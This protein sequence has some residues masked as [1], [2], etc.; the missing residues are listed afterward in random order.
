LWF[1]D[2]FQGGGAVYNV[3]A[4]LRLRGALDGGALRSALDEL[5]SRHES[6]RT[7]FVERAG[8]M[9]QAIDP[10]GPMALER[11]DLSGR[12]GALAGLLEA[13][14]LRPFDLAAGPLVRAA[15]YRLSG[16]E[17]VLLLSMH[18]IVTDGWSLKL[19]YRELAA[20]YGAF[21]AGLPSPLPAPALHYADY[22]A[23]QGQWLRGA[24]PGR[25]LDYWKRRLAGAPEVLELPA[26]RPRPAVQ[27]FR[28]AEHGFSVSGEQLAGL[29]AI[30]RGAGA[31]LFAVLMAAFQATLSRLSGQEDVLVGL[32]V[33]G[34]R[35]ETEGLI[36]FFVNTLVLRTDLSGEPDFVALVGRVWASLLDAYDHQEVPFEK[37]V[38]KVAP[39]RDPSR[40]PVFQVMMAYQVEEEAPVWPAAVTA[41]PEPV[42]LPVAKFDLSLD[43]VE[44]ADGLDLRLDYATDLFDAST[45]AR[46]AG[47]FAALLEGAV[48]APER[49]VSRLALLGEA[50]LERLLVEWNDTA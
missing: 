50:E 6:L 5:V 49:P 22:A 34:R 30:A 28:G 2:R 41:S 10:A 13:Q 37:V 35:P 17:H 12:P 27:S 25:Q 45:I 47:C 38:E 14:A 33:A 42:A 32:P 26:D 39:V 3:P 29:R 19:L 16:D 40:H 7:R 20:L 23:W 48:S 46:F 31:S 9:V 24:E 15:L 43:V 4:G 1:L 8:V 21:A 44:R 36:G 18:H 11:V